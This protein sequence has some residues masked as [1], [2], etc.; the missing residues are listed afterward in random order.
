VDRSRAGDLHRRSGLREVHLTPILK[1]ERRSWRQRS[2][3]P[4]IVRA[5]GGRSP[6]QP[7]TAEHGPCPPPLGPQ[8]HAA[9]I[10]ADPRERSRHNAADT[11]VV[12]SHPGPLKT[13][14]LQTNANS[15]I[16]VHI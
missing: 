16:P 12:V 15:D 11:C 9:R 6:Q 3:A 13:P 4:G 7:A 2:G 5:S 10:R 1:V 8:C 14:A